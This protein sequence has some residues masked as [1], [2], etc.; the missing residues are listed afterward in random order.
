MLKFVTM[1]FQ[2]NPYQVPILGK[3]IPSILPRKDPREQK[4]QTSTLFP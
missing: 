3:S 2:M 4:G 1:E